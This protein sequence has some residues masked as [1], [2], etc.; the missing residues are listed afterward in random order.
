MGDQV[1]ACSAAAAAAA[2]TDAVRSGK[3]GEE[4]EKKC[5]SREGKIFTPCQE[6]HA[7][8]PERE[9]KIGAC[10][11]AS[12]IGFLKVLCAYHPNM[13]AKVDRRSKLA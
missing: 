11:S 4:K 12:I 9:S 2:K 1:V 5:L 6:K 8:K 13:P 3:K 7:R 10:V